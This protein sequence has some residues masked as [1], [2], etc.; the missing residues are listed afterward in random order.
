MK[1]FDFKFKRLSAM[2]RSTRNNIREELMRLYFDNG[3]SGNGK[4]TIKLFSLDESDIVN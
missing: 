4:R 1:N 3:I 2:N